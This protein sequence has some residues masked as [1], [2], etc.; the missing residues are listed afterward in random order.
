MADQPGILFDSLCF[1]FQK[2]LSTIEGPPPSKGPCDLILPQ[3]IAINKIRKTSHSLSADGSR[4]T[5]SRAAYCSGLGKQQGRKGRHRVELA[6]RT[7]FNSPH[8]GAPC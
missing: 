5:T 8:P 1:T 6:T 7:A 4:L 2:S 3:N